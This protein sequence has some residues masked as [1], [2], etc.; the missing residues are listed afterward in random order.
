MCAFWILLSIF[1]RLQYHQMYTHTHTTHT[2]T[3]TYTHTPHTP[4]QHTH[5]AALRSLASAPV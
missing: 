3:H 1:V 2:H 5:G 4:P